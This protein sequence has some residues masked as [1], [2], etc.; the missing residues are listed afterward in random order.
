MPNELKPCK[1][2]GRARAI[3]YI[4]NCSEKEGAYSPLVCAIVFCEECDE[5]TDEAYAL[6]VAIDWW[7]RRA[8]DEQAD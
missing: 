3:Q 7:N 6:E 4:K 8:N 1:C 5:K 2:G